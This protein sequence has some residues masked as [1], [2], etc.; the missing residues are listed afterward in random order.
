MKKLQCYFFQYNPTLLEPVNYWY[1]S[2][3]IYF[4]S[5]SAST[6]NIIFTIALQANRRMRVSVIVRFRLFIYIFSLHTLPSSVILSSSLLQFSFLN[7]K[8]IH[9]YLFNFSWTMLRTF[10]AVSLDV[11]RNEMILTGERL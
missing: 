11:T 7:N 3:G 8:C 10:Y 6:P 2:R 9:I 4:T 5:S 1:Y